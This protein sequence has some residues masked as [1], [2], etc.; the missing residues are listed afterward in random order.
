MEK[1]EATEFID[2]WNTDHEAEHKA[3][4]ELNCKTKNE[5]SLISTDDEGSDDTN[6]VLKHKRNDPT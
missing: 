6:T 5:C 2:K 4:W 1:R 3:E